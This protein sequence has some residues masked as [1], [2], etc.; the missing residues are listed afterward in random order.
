MEG[1]YD[2]EYNCVLLHCELTKKE[3]QAKFRQ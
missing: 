1:N 2:F 3:K